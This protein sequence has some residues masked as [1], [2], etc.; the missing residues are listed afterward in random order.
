LERKAQT[1]A[2]AW[3]YYFIADNMSSANPDIGHYIDNQKIRAESLL[4]KK[5]T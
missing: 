2:W 3:F 4:L 1:H 5:K